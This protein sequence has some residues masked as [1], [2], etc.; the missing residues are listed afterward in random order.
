[1]ERLS[2]HVHGRG[3]AAFCR[4]YGVCVAFFAAHTLPLYIERLQ[5]TVLTFGYTPWNIVPRLG[6]PLDEPTLWLLQ[7]LLLA[8]GVSLAAGV[9]PRCC[10]AISFG[11]L[12]HVLA[13]DR[14]IYNNHYVLM[15]ELSALLLAVD[16]R[17]LSW[18][19][20]QLAAGRVTAAPTLPRWQRLS[21]QLLLL[22]PYFYGGVAKL[23]RSW[24]FDAEVRPDSTRMPGLM[25]HRF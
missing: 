16:E 5:H 6:D 8:S 22:T 21:L 1:M 18:P 11:A 13:L 12:L 23:N 14:I 15:L 9:L 7:R 10:L 4:G 25:C 2:A 17:C 20:P 19:W 3:V 24:L